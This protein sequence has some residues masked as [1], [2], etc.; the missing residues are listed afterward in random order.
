MTETPRLL[1]YPG[2][3]VSQGVAGISYISGTSHCCLGHEG[4]SDWGN[5]CLKS[6]KGGA[7]CTCH[8]EV[9]CLRCSGS[10]LKCS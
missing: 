7:C 6:K 8:C 5:T 3:K 9:L 1:V 2:R 10:S 4:E